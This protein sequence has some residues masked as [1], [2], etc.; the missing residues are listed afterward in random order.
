MTTIDIRLI[1]YLNLFERITGV[2]SKNC[3][4]YNNSI[5]F[6]VPSFSVSKAIGENGRNVKRV[7]EILG[8]NIKIVSL[9]RGINDAERFIRG[10]IEP[11]TFKSLEVSQE[12][13]IIAASRQS[14]ASLIGRNKVRLEELKK[15]VKDFFGKELKIV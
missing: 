7:S 8:K 1:R 4:F 3:F 11:I 5:F 14:K 6:A 15:V 2:S 9:P 13:I 10:I 12:A